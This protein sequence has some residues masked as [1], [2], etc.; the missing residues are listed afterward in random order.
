[1]GRFAELCGEVAASMEEGVEGLTLRPKPGT[2]SA[3]TGR[4]KTSKDAMGLVQ[5]SLMLDELVDAA[6]SLSGRHGRLAGP[7][8]A[9]RLRTRAP[10]PARP[11]VSLDALGQLTRRVARLEEALARL[12]R[13]VPAANPG[14]RT[15]RV[16]L[17]NQGI[18]EEM[19]SSE[20]EG[21]YPTPESDGDEE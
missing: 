16:R 3:P 11:R 8:S 19:R 21:E 6:D 15:L 4:R 5:E 7:I 2:A 1:M 12:S 14:S 9:P 10:R 17:A 13:Q 18:E 20:D